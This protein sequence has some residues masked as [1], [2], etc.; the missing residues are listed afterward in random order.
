MDRS[1]LWKN[2]SPNELDVQGR[3]HPS[4]AWPPRPM[5]AKF[6]A[7]SLKRHHKKGKKAKNRRRRRPRAKARVGARAGPPPR[8]DKYRNQIM[9][10]VA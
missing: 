8:C 4:P 7:G 9:K 6:P 1:E 2:I 3:R 10:E 5:S